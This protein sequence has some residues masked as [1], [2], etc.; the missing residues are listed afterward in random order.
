MY[1]NIFFTASVFVTKTPLFNLMEKTEVGVKAERVC[2][3]G[4]GGCAA[5][6]EWSIGSTIEAAQPSSSKVTKSQWGKV[7]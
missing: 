7:I 3:G 1:A 2:G 6:Q 5:M 4:G